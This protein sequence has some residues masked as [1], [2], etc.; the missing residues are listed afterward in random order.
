MNI[1]KNTKIYL[2]GII[3]LFHLGG[4]VFAGRLNFAIWL[5][6][7]NFF[8]DNKP[9]VL[10]LKNNKGLSFVRDKVSAIEIDEYYDIKP[11]LPEAYNSFN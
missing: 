1:T 10:Y 2:M 9:P 7:R 6:K 3:S 8:F 11:A 4:D 5:F